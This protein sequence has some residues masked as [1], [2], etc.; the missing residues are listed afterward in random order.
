[1]QHRKSATACVNSGQQDTAAYLCADTT[2]T[3]QAIVSTQSA[4][5]YYNEASCS[6]SAQTGPDLC[7][8]HSSHEMPIATHAQAAQA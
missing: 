8:H 7:I 3:R 6:P 1:M 2:C 5:L 4:L